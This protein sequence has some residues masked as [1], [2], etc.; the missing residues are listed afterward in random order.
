[1]S[2]KNKNKKLFKDFKNTFMK[3]INIPLEK[4]N[5][6]LNELKKRLKINKNYVKK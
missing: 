6:L 4:R 3:E 2:I 1:M 5:L